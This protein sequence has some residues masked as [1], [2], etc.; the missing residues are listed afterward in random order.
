MMNKC[1]SIQLFLIMI[2]CVTIISCNGYKT[3]DSKDVAEEVN[4]KKLRNKA[5]EKD[6]QYLV[7]AAAAS[8]NTI[9]IAD[10]ALTTATKN[11]IKEFAARLKKDHNAIAAQLKE[12][13]G[14]KALTV[15][16]ESTEAGNE[17]AAKLLKENVSGFNKAWLAQMKDLNEYCIKT[18]ESAAATVQDSTIRHWFTSSLATIKSQGAT[19]TQ[20]SGTINN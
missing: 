15:P 9:K 13:A 10:V 19:I 8:F 17:N 14:R 7:D 2:C 20:M 11:E 6:A 4:D 16:T 12:I 3:A 5:A 18:Y 1:K